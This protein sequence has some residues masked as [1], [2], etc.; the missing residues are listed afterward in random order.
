MTY[1]NCIQSNQVNSGMTWPIVDNLL[2]HYAS[3]HNVL[4]KVVMYE[5]ELASEKL[6]EELLEK[7]AIVQELITRDGGIVDSKKQ[8]VIAGNDGGHD[9]DV[10]TDGVQGA[11]AMRVIMENMKEEVE[12]LKHKVA[13][14]NDSIKSLK[15]ELNTSK[16]CLQNYEQRYGEVVKMNVKLQNE[17]GNNRKVDSD[18]T[19]VKAAMPSSRST[20]ASSRRNESSPSSNT[21][22]RSEV[23]GKEDDGV[24]SS[25]AFGSSQAVDSPSEQHFFASGNNSQQELEDLRFKVARLTDQNESWQKHN[26]SLQMEIENMHMQNENLKNINEIGKSTVE[27]SNKN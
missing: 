18:T 6:R 16:V 10:H 12:S 17:V 27:A 3:H 5:S 20:N 14:K 1:M 11:K 2:F 26:D 15:E 8:S 4:E 21:S 24:S 23:D 13:M 19:R 25:G 9:N 7:E 22:S